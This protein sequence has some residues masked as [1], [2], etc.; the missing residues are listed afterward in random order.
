ML[1]CDLDSESC[2]LE[3]ISTGPFHGLDGAGEGQGGFK[4]DLTFLA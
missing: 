4:E 1:R 2:G 3:G